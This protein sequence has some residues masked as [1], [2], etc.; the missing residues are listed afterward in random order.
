MGHCCLVGFDCF[1]VVHRLLV[2]EN[3]AGCRCD[4]VFGGLVLFGFDYGCLVHHS[5]FRCLSTAG[6]H[7]RGCHP[8]WFGLRCPWFGL[9]CA[10]CLGCSWFVLPWCVPWGLLRGFVF[11][12]LCGCRLSLWYPF[13]V[14]HC[15]FC[16]GWFVGSGVPLV[17]VGLWF[18]FCLVQVCAVFCYWLWQ[19]R[20][21]WCIL[22]VA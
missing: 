17:G 10:G 7:T 2:S 4:P 19:C 6:C 14:W 12:V 8:Q 5:Y 20:L 16:S 21:D 3:R 9:A 15:C 1:V 11:G 18:G 22:L 13:H